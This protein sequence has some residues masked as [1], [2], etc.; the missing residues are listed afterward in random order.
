MTGR[1]ASRSRGR[2]SPA[3]SNDPPLQ[4]G[5]PL[6][7]DD[8]R[9]RRLVVLPLCSPLS[10]DGPAVVP[11]GRP[12]LRERVTQE[13]YPAAR[14]LCGRPVVVV[15]QVAQHVPAAHRTVLRKRPRCPRDALVEPLMCAS[16]DEVYRVLGEHTGQ[17]GLT[18]D[19]LVIQT[20]LA[21]GADPALGVSVGIRGAARGVDDHDAGA[22]P[23]GAGRAAGSGSTEFARRR[24][25]ARGVTAMI[26]DA[27][28]GTLGVATGRSRGPSHSWIAV[29]LRRDPSGRRA[30]ASTRVRAYP[31]LLHTSRVQPGRLILACGHGAGRSVTGTEARKK[32]SGEVR[33]TGADSVSAHGGDRGEARGCYG[34]PR[35]RE[36]ISQ[37]GAGVRA[38][39]LAPAPSTRS[40]Q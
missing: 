11:E 19:E 31:S 38:G 5:P 32:R 15:E 6:P 12:G 40:G 1:P 26:V 4:R 18:E 28:A 20:F 29:Q 8:H 33:S 24:R 23:S 27:A 16:L 13:R 7:L 39:R 14:T 37:S 10:R 9:P 3:E 21:G 34:V 30:P 35:W 36:R 22:V 25:G 2:E 17:M